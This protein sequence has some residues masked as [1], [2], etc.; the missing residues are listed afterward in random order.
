MDINQTLSIRS[1]PRHVLSLSLGVCLALAAGQAFAA[2]IPAAKK[3]HNV[4]ECAT[5]LG[6]KGDFTVKVIPARPPQWKVELGPDGKP[7]VVRAMDPRIQVISTSAPSDKV[8]SDSVP[9]WRKAFGLPNPKVFTASLTFGFG[10]ESQAVGFDSSIRDWR[11]AAANR[12]PASRLD[13]SLQRRRNHFYSCSQKF[14]FSTVL[15]TST[16]LEFRMSGS[17][18]HLVRW[19]VQAPDPGPREHESIQMFAFC[20]TSVIGTSMLLG[21][22]HLTEQTVVFWSQS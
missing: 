13:H 6:L 12:P 10:V 5:K 7:I 3:R 15:S 11:L 1:S 16:D 18:A 19:G 17:E 2:K 20:L 9:C 21:P 14:G 8:V 22:L 4:E